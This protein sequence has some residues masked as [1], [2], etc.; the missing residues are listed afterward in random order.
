MENAIQ[1][2]AYLFRASRN[3]RPVLLLGAGDSFRS[4]IPMAGEATKRIARAA[5]SRQVLGADEELGN[6]T[7][8]DW[9][10]FLQQQPWFIS[11]PQRFAENF[12]LAVE[13]LL[14][15][16]EFRR[17]FFT[18]M[19]TPPNGINPG[20][21][22][23]AKLMMRRL[24]WTVMTTNFDH[25]IVESLRELHSHIP[26][27][28]EINRTTD[29]LVRFSVYNRCQVVYLHG[30]VEY[31]RDKNLVEEVRR[32]DDQLVRRIRPIITYSPLIVI[33]YRG[34]EPSIMS[35]LLGEGVEESGSY[36]Q[37]IY[38]CLLR[39]EEPHENVRELQAQIGRNFQ[40]IEIV[41][42]VPLSRESPC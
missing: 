33:G 17:E 16:A 23:L 3:T 42:A 37:G 41:G 40:L 36:R 27:V 35:H 26:E 31:Y 30:A 7:P 11:D 12:P 2:L 15:P 22:H 14:H 5:Y 32:L 20:Y 34:S 24:C 13:N 6:P 10:P 8:S 9:M 1:A 4:G 19:I 29:D 25:N 28:V 38:W 21:Q 39:G 18:K